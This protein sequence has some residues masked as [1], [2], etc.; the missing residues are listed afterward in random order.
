ML[1]FTD[2]QLCHLGGMSG[3]A[4]LRELV[5]CGNALDTL[6]SLPHLPALR[7]LNVANNRLHTL[8]PGA[9]ARVPLLS[10]LSIAR[11]RVDFPGRDCH[12]AFVSGSLLHLAA[13]NVAGN[14]AGSLRDVA[15]LAVL[16]A[17]VSLSFEDV[18]GACPLVSLAHYHTA[19]RSAVPQLT[20]LDGSDVDAGSA[21]GEA[22]KTT[23]QWR[24]SCLS[25]VKAL[26]RT[27]DDVRSF[28]ASTVH[29]ARVRAHQLAVAAHTAHAELEAAMLR[30]DIAPVTAAARL[31]ALTSSKEAATQHA[32]ALD[33]QHGKAWQAA[34]MA[35]HEHGQLAIDHGV[36]CA[37]NVLFE[38]DENGT[39]VAS[40]QWRDF[41]LSLVRTRGSSEVE[42]AAVTAG[43][44]AEPPLRLVHA[45]R[46]RNR[47]LGS[48]FRQASH[49]VA[50]AIAES[51]AAAQRAPAWMGQSGNEDEDEV[52]N[53]SDP[54]AMAGDDGMDLDS[55]AGGSAAGDQLSDGVS[56]DNESDGYEDMD[57]DGYD[58]DYD[59]DGD[60]EDGG[61]TGIFSLT[62]APDGNKDPTLNVTALLAAAAPSSSAEHVWLFYARAAD[63]RGA[64][65]D[66][67]SLH[68][69]A[70]EGF[71]R[72]QA[73]AGTIQLFTRPGDALR[74]AGV[75]CDAGTDTAELL[76][77]R[78]CPGVVA[79]PPLDGDIAQCLGA[80]DAL[81]A[82][83]APPESMASDDTAAA[84]HMYMC[85]TPAL[86]LPEFI[87]HVSAAGPA[88][89]D[90]IDSIWQ[91]P[92]CVAVPPGAQPLLRPLAALLVRVRA[93]TSQLEATCSAVLA[94]T[95][96]HPPPPQPL[97]RP[98]SSAT[99]PSSSTLTVLSLHGA[100]LKDGDLAALQLETAVPQLT[101]LVLSGNALTRLDGCQ[102]LTRLT[103]LVACDNSLQR[104][105]LSDLPAATLTSLDLARNPLPVL[106]DLTCLRSLPGLTDLVL[107]GTGM[108]RNGA[109]RG[110]VL[111]R[112][113]G[114]KRLDGGDVTAEEVET[115]SQHSSA[116]TP[117]AL[118]AGSST[119]AG[120]AVVAPDPG[121]SDLTWL[122]TIAHLDL[123][124]A[125]LRRLAGMPPLKGLVSA[126]LACNLLSED[127]VAEALGSSRGLTHLDVSYTAVT[128][129]APLGAA[130]GALTRLH[131][132]GNAMAD[133]TTLPGTVPGRLPFSHLTLLSLEHCGLTSLSAFGPV[134]GQ[135]PLPALEELY[136]GNNRIA[137]LPQVTHLRGLARLAVLQL[138]GNPMCAST[139]PPGAGGGDGATYRLYVAHTV[140]HIAI[141]DGVPVSHREGAAAA[142]AFAAGLTPAV[143]DAALRRGEG[144]AAAA[145]G[146]QGPPTVCNLTDQQLRSLGGSSSP[147]LS[148]G[149]TL[150]SVIVD[151]NPALRSLH[152]LQ[153]LPHLKKVSAAK[154]AL[155]LGAPPAEA[156][157]AS[158]AAVSFY[159]ELQHLD[160]SHNALR[161]LGG[162]QLHRMA[163]L[164]SLILDGNV[165][166]GSTLAQQQHS[167]GNSTA[168][169]ASAAPVVLPSLTLL[170][171]QG[172]AIG[173][174]PP[175]FL[176]GL[177]CLQTL[178]LGN[179]RLKS[180]APWL[181]G[182]EQLKALHVDGNRLGDL[183]EATALL[184]RLGQLAELT[185]TGNALAKAQNYR[186]TLAAA[187]LGLAMLD[188]QP[189]TDAELSQAAAITAAAAAKKNNALKGRG[190][191]EAT[192]A[193]L[194]GQPPVA[195]TAQ[196]AVRVPP[197]SGVLPPALLRA[198]L[199]PAPIAPAGAASAAGPTF[200]SLAGLTGDVSSD[201]LS[202]TLAQLHI[203][204]KVPE[205]QRA[206]P[207]GGVTSLTA[208]AGA[209][210][211]PPVPP[212]ASHAAKGG[213]VSTQRKPVAAKAPDSAGTLGLSVTGLGRGAPQGGANQR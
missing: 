162:L 69:V 147:L 135:Q 4:K 92:E 6:H 12:A 156:P 202:A 97:P 57:G 60:G 100:G 67:L 186:P 72:A 138:A 34:Y 101:R 161:H 123:A 210:S 50:V 21:G 154:C 56:P 142:A 140:P 95:A 160:V 203:P 58:D 195:R 139:S 64:A 159:P 42:V 199:P 200:M 36:T 155:G 206:A 31:A 61:A 11:N 111:R 70:E 192:L 32:A 204:S 68:R 77:L 163:A 125:G 146:A 174:L 79:A 98:L 116:L 189:F 198:P 65:S 51:A 62:D 59:D 113:V 175:S 207:S 176:G 205:Q 80:C 38:E 177:P 7:T 86:V 188:G 23:A 81:L 41:C 114:L 201:A 45:V 118:A 104:L 193:R 173:A 196:Q 132:D 168:V 136:A 148:V 39:G 108:A 106:E 109:Y 187:C 137:D 83:V 55:D 181:V 112:A 130:C 84:A 180:L 53:A 10:E 127:D 3:L 117:A 8:D 171:L 164:R 179:N 133:V 90:A 102:A 40:G 129:L 212:P 27:A 73:A 170:S 66:V 17:L 74:H 18:H 33:V 152:P 20:C 213:G 16:P 89:C 1:W 46:I 178:R 30:F 169:S 194:T 182:H 107:S 78:V 88:A 211:M 149:A 185:L 145:S 13:L 172:C 9:L 126:R 2:C 37:G 43:T 157:A 19:V 105:L 5:V 141:L 24:R 91:E 75:A 131:A 99:I 115:A 48:T 49:R 153:V 14:P 103:A 143:L 151:S 29:R 52:N 26:Q 96:L 82:P 166:L 25:R 184:P 121:S 158:T 209:A 165:G 144:D 47:H 44:T 87:L 94:N 85:L 28:V 134:G 35:L 119:A 183:S 150:V 197:T 63:P 124:Y 191:L 208:P 15:L 128:T 22:L 120:N 93:D 190:N 167:S 76:V 71:T 54:D 122:D 110:V